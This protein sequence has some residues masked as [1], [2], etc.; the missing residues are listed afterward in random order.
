MRMRGGTTFGTL[1]RMRRG[2]RGWTGLAELWT[3]RC[4]MDF[5][6]CAYEIVFSNEDSADRYIDEQKAE[7][8]LGMYV[9][10]KKH[11]V[12]DEGTGQYHG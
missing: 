8:E 9:C 5:G 3:V 12:L 10:Y 2:W 4:S 1:T 11:L 7:D 6:E